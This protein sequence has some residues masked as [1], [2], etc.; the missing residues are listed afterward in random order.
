MKNINYNTWSRTS[1]TVYQNTRH[2]NNFA[3]KTS[4]LP[5]QNEYNIVKLTHKT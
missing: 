5:D 4:V 1:N 3:N 2:T